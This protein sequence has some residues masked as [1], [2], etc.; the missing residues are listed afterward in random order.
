MS[1]S[2]CSPRSIRCRI[3]PRNCRS[4]ASWAP[5]GAAWSGNSGRIERAERRKGGSVAK[6][7]ALVLLLLGADVAWAQTPALPVTGEPETVY[8]EAQRQ[9]DIS[10]SRWIVDSLLRPS[11]SIDNVYARWK[12]PVCPHVYGLRPVAAWLIEHRI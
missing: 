8:S 7:L 12:L 1:I 10:A 3:F 11:F 5:C 9:K 6:A 4:S 2:R